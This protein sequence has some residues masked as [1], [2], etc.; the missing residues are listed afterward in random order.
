MAAPAAI[1]SCAATGVLFAARARAD[2]AKRCI[3]TATG[4]Y[5]YPTNS[6]GSPAFVGCARANRDAV[7]GGGQPLGNALHCP[8]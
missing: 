7:R 3:A 8:S 4:D 1:T 6:Q 5:V 2:A